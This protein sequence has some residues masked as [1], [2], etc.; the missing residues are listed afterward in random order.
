MVGSGAKA[1][2][3]LIAVFPY[4]FYFM[5]FSRGIF[6]VELCTYAII[7]NIIMNSCVDTAIMPC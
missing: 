3:S 4:L 2:V 1:I 5:Y 7:K 6:I